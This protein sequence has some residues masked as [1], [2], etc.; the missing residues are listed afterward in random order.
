MFLFSLNIILIKCPFSHN[1]K[2]NTLQIFFFKQTN[3]NFYK[4]NYVKKLQ[5]ISKNAHKKNTE[6][7]I[8]PLM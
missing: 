5:K 2:Q 8:V 4:F 7:I 6:F 3:K 1:T